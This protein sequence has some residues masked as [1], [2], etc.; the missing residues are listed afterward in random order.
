MRPSS[1]PP[2]TA[3]AVTRDV[4]FWIGLILVCVGGF[5]FY[6]ATGFDASSRVFPMVVSGLLT[7]CGL[8]LLLRRLR[9]GLAKP[10]PA[11]ELGATAICV[12]LV[13]GWVA[14]LDAG[15]GFALSTFVLQAGLLWLSGQRDPVRLVLV[16]ALV[17]VV[18]Y[19]L[20]V[21]VLDVRLPRS[22]LS[23]IAPGL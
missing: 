17:T 1:Q 19:L 11:R 23:F 13:G 3:G 2:A 21:M 4:D 16:A 12:V 22:F 10:L 8:A 20:F 6:K 7:L 5:A 14:A 18:T 9:A 15:A